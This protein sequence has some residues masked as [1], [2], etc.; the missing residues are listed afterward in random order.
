MA[1][2]PI[3][4]P[5]PT[6]IHP[7]I[8]SILLPRLAAISTNTTTSSSPDVSIIAVIAIILG[9]VVVL[10][11]I[12]C[13]VRAA[14][15]PD[16]LPPYQGGAQPYGARKGRIGVVPVGA[17][18]GGAAGVGIGAME[19]D[20][21]VFEMA[22]PPPAYTGDGGANSGTCGGGYSGDGGAG[23]ASGAAA[24]I[25]SSGPGSGGGGGC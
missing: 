3:L 19:N 24:G 4:E 22:A 7:H 11:V 13:C 15:G 9:L 18:S 17:V 5:V 21:G 16:P 20:S 2:L 6:F 12:A 25:N 23:T 8:P 1:P 10:S 14:R